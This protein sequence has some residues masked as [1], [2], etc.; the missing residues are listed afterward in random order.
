[1]TSLRRTP[2]ATDNVVPLRPVLPG[3][4]ALRSGELG[5]RLGLPRD[6]RLVQIAFLGIL[7]S[8][9]VLL[10]DFSLQPVQMLLTF[11]A[12]L[13]TQ[14]VWI[15]TLRLSRKG[16]LSA[17]VTCLGLSILLRADSVWVH[18]LA[19]CLAI[20]AKFAL[21]VHG[22]HVFNPANLG[23][24]VATTLLPGA[25]ISPGQWGNDL[26]AACW[27]VVLGGLVT[28][29]A[30]RSDIAWTFLL[31]WLGVIVVRVAWLGQAWSVWWHQLGSG[32]LLLFAF[33]M[34]SDPMTIPDDRRA[35][36]AYALLVTLL[37]YAWQFVLYRPNALVFALFLATPAVPLL[38]RLFPS[39]RFEWHG[40]RPA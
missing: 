18:P 26:A 27:F 12:G 16:Y 31:A 39:R 34:I 1:M 7:L 5:P 33:F 19:A 20:S 10:R 40:V 22:K 9:G 8:F 30:Q 23:V 6:A 25:W 36:V 28:G 17:V 14:A 32:A 24:V 21:R 2:A 11:S 15:V 4:A 3:P 35:R 37:A 29:R 38:D 13:I